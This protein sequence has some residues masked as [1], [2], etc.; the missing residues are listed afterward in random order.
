MKVLYFALA[1][2]TAIGSRT[3]T[4]DWSDYKPSTIAKAWSETTVIKG[5][6][7]TIETR[8]VKYAVEVSYSG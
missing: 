8:D 4:Q 1:F 5:T 6:D 3:Q 2:M 7:Y